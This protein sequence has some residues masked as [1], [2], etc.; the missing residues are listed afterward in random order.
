MRRAAG[1]A[2]V[3]PMRQAMKRHARRVVS[4]QLLFQARRAYVHVASR[5]ARTAFE[6]ADR[7]PEWLEPSMLPLLQ[8]RYPAGAQYPYD[9]EGISRR[10]AE[11]ARF[12]SRFLDGSR[13]T[14][15]V[16]C[17]DAM[18]SCHLAGAG[19]KATALDLDDSCDPRAR[20]SGVEL[21]EADASR[22]PFDGQQYDLVFSY[23]AFEHFA[24]PEAVLGEMARVTKPGGVVYAFFGPLYRSSYGLHATLS[25]RV[26]FC[27]FLFDRP[28]LRAYVAENDLPPIPF[29]TLNEWTLHQFR[30]L[31]ARYRPYLELQMYREIPDHHGIELIAAH[32]SC[33]RGGVD[34]FEELVLGTIEAVFR[35]TDRPARISSRDTALSEQRT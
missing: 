5:R 35:R 26:P 31:W 29:E 10:G 8:R 3:S 22:M 7:E 17:Q 21:V 9:P 18:V 28:A 30:D 15:E 20:E 19:A 16:G 24:D 11:R 32:P 14:L 2:T 23:N 1:F 13:R 34:E 6:H 12:L 33:F 25:V 4:P 27:Q